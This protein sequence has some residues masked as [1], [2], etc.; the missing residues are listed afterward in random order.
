MLKTCSAAFPEEQSQRNLTGLVLL[1]LLAA[2]HA[3]LTWGHISIFSGDTGRWL[4]DVQRYAEGETLYRDFTWAFPPLGMWIVGGAARLFGSSVNV[5]WTA[6]LIIYALLALTYFKYVSMLLPRKLATPAMA[7]AF[8][9]AAAYA[10]WRDTPLPLGMYTPSLPLGLLFL[11]M[12]CMAC[13][14]FLESLK[15]MPALCVGLFCALALLAKHEFWIPAAY[16]MAVTCV[17]CRVQSPKAKLPACAAMLAVFAAVFLGGYTLVVWQTDWNTLVASL[18]GFGHVAEFKGRSYPT[19]EQLSGELMTVGVWAIAAML[20]M[21]LGRALEWKQIRKPL[22]ICGAGLA[23]VAGFHAW[24]SWREMLHYAAASGESVPQGVKLLMTLAVRL[25]SAVQSH[26]F[27]FFGPIVMGALIAWRWKKIES[28]RLRN[29][30]VLLLGLCLAARSR[31]LASLVLWFNFLLELPVYTLAAHLLLPKLN[32]QPQRATRL[33][34]AGLLAVAAFSYWSLSV[35]PLTKRGKLQRVE[36][37]RGTVYLSPAEA[38]RFSKMKTELERLDPHG[39]R[40][41]FAFGSSGGYNYFYGR[42]NP[43]PASQGFHFTKFPP[44]QMVTEVLRQ[45]PAAMVIETKLYDTMVTPVPEFRPFRWNAD[46]R[47]IHFVRYDRPL[48]DRITA[49]CPQVATVE[50]PGPAPF[51]IHDCRATNLAFDNSRKRP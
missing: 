24:M 3:W 12:G 9:L 33:A 43:T 39:I 4:Y 15:T 37:A 38:I 5:I 26:L 27:P 22:A 23:L 49:Q 11:L 51:H 14:R 10:S 45:F 6:T 42:R 17:T 7:V 28:T 32:W 35:G 18:G 8:I 46:T 34:F 2:A 44:E 19:G 48:F 25:R 1:F 16:V 47:P 50:W 21:W 29:A 40:P 36:T 20:A 31:R 13:F 30:V 41:L